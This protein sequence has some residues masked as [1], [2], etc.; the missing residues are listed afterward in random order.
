[1]YKQTTKISTTLRECRMKS[2]STSSQSWINIYPVFNIENDPVCAIITSW[3]GIEMY[4]GVRTFVSMLYRD[5][6]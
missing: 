1:M 5:G 2:S 4:E 3:Q 6:I